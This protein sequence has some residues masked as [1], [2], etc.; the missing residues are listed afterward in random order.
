M[1]SSAQTPLFAQFTVEQKNSE[2]FETRKHDH[3]VDHSNS[4]IAAL[5][6]WVLWWLCHQQ[7][8][9]HTACSGSYRSC[10]QPSPGPKCDLALA[11][12]KGNGKANNFW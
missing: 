6:D 10:T 5:A 3:V 4:V 2:H 11:T 7:P 1:W 12:T 8:D 9:S